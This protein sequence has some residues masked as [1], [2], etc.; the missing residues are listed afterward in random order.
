MSSTPESSSHPF[1]KTSADV[2]LRSSDG[3]QFRVHKIILSEASSVFDGMFTLPQLDEGEVPVALPSVDLTED[4]KTIERLLRLCYPMD[5]PEIE[6][7]DVP[8]VVR[9]ARKYDMH[10]AVDRVVKT[11]M[12]QSVLE[13]PQ[14]ALRVY[15]VTSDLDLPQAEMAARASLWEPLGKDL[16]YELNGITPA[17]LYRLLDYRRRVRAEIIGYLVDSQLWSFTD[18]FNINPHRWGIYSDSPVGVVLP[19]E[20]F[21]L[22]HGHSFY[23]NP[24]PPYVQIDQAPVL[25][26][27]VKQVKN[28]KDIRA[29]QVP[30]ELKS[31]LSIQFD[32]C[33][34]CFEAANDFFRKFFVRLRESVE[35]MALEVPLDADDD[36]EEF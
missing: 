28:L 13:N 31:A 11:F 29:L 5:D 10:W 12:Q 36:S 21:S 25:L 7:E 33:D 6:L 20:L 18:E 15:T 16:P 30:G 4:G 8:C 2:V 3:I 19:Q 34:S 9:A 14:T 27:L 32:Q 35:K 26:D 1:T 17:S 24:Y 23:S 22:N